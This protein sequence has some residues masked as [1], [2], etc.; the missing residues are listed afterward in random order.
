MNLH[1]GHAAHQH[2]LKSD[3][4]DRTWGWATDEELK[5]V[6]EELHVE[7]NR[8]DKEPSQ[9]EIQQWSKLGML[10]PGKG[11][12]EKKCRRQKRTLASPMYTETHH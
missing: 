4:S 7:E 1:K 8:N 12:K 6:L 2:G 10:P 11:G 3:R 9:V 5:P